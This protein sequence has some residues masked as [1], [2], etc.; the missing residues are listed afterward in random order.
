MLPKGWAEATVEELAGAAGYVSDGDWIE[1][2]DQ[3]PLG[4]V[5]LIQLADIG[6]GR[7]I[8]KSARFLTKDTALRLKCSKLKQGDVLIARMPDPIGRAC[9]F[10]GLDQD[11]ITV[12]DVLLWRS[13][14]TLA[15]PAWF[16]KWFNSPTVQERMKF[17]AT[18]TTRQRVA[19]GRIKNMCFPFPPLAEQRRI[20]AKLD[21]LT[22]RIARTR[23]EL[24]R[25]KKNA[26][27]V[28]IATLQKA[29]HWNS[30]NLPSGWARKKIGEIG[31]VQLGRQRS[32]KDHFGPHMRPYVRSA[33]ITWDGWDLSDVK[34]MNFSPEEFEVFKLK[35]GDVLL[36]EGSGSPSEVGKPAIWKGRSITYVSK[37]LF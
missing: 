26:N 22:A 13:D 18:G 19:G 7:F 28:K 25:V 30:K 6:V 9:I 17:E 12:V 21:S 36:N 31:E 20:V 2:K 33:N 15:L 8:N 35:S 4:E 14:C 34:E 1:S 32:P 16:E 11:A 37:T 5:R 24:K 27:Q 10:P 3:N 23:V 29:F